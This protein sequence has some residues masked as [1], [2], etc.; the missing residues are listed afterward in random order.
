MKKYILLIHLVIPYILLAQ[1]FTFTVGTPMQG[2]QIRGGFIIDSVLK[3]PI[4]DTIWPAAYTSVTSEACLVFNRM[5]HHF[6]YNDS[7]VWQ[8]VLSINDA[9]SLFLTSVPA[10][11]FASLTSKPT[12]LAGYGIVDAYPLSGNPSGFISSINSG[13]VTTALGYTPLSAEV[14]G[15]V[16]NEIE[17]PSQTGNSGKVLSTNGTTPSWVT[18]GGFTISTFAAGAR[19]FSTAYQFTS[20]GD[21][22]IS[23]SISCNLSLSGGQAGN[24]QL[25]VS[26]NGTT[27][28]VTYATLSASNTGTLT[29][30]LNTTQVSG[31]QLTAPLQAGEYWR[32][33][34]T[35]TTGTPTYTAL[36]G[37]EKL[38]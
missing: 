14:D 24:I 11:S 19:S 18:S 30:G 35:N 9:N 15:S 13:M 38:Y 26:P 3:I 2:Q 23:V 29:I 10:Q 28:W 5:D 27:G 21:I 22:S 4:K 1:N 16:T 33:I 6:Y 25:Q 31:G 17:L 20:R 37:F 12:T 7:L 32:I 8:R 34:S 36:A